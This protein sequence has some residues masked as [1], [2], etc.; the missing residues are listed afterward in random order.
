MHRGWEVTARLLAD[1]R[2][3]R[4]TVEAALGEAREVFF[5]TAEHIA[6]VRESLAD[7]S[8]LLSLAR[9]QLENSRVLLQRASRSSLAL[10]TATP[11]RRRPEGAERT[12]ANE[13]PRPTGTKA[14]P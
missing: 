1:E 14:V 7:D 2:A 6:L 11:D 4:S 12:R 8:K 13:W 3:L 5:E 9:E 10:T